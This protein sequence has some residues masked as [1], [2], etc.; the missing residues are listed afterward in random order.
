MKW[1]SGIFLAAIC[2]SVQAQDNFLRQLEASP[3]HQEWVEIMSNGRKLKCFVV[4]PEVSSKAGSV[5]VIHE[6]RGLNDWARSMADQIAGGGFIAIAPDLLSGMAPNGGGTADFPNPDAA[7]DAIY[8]LDS[9]QV[10]KDL[11]AVADYVTK[12]PSSNGKVAVAGYCWGG[13]QCFRMATN[14]EKIKA[15][16]VFYGTGPDDI[17]AIRSIKA[18]VYG[19][20][21]GNDER[22]NATIPKSDSLMK[23]NGKKYEPVIYTGAGH[24]FMRAGQE[25]NATADNTKARD[26]AFARLIA[27]LKEM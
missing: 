14:N 12:L 8:K 26:E 15:A 2:F 11:N 3:R 20:Y 21:G 24:G 16:F 1:I 4:Y 27:K 17:S 5:V 13:S 19:F 23:A 10:R 18:P 25:P 9:A 6:N 7:R 22:V